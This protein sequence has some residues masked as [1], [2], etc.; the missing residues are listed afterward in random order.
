MTVAPGGR[1]ILVEAAGI[2]AKLLDDQQTVK[3]TL[4][5]AAEQAK[6]TVL[7]TSFHKFSPQGVSGVVVIAESHISI[8][9]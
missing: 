3:D 9:T 5:A 6:C 2:D 4:V 8:H 7:E 1:H